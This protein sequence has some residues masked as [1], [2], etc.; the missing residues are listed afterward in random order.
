MVPDQV[1]GR[2]HIIKS[3]VDQL[4]DRQNSGPCWGVYSRFSQEKTVVVHSEGNRSVVRS[5]LY[6]LVPSQGKNFCQGREKSVRHKWDIQTVRNLYPYLDFFRG[7]KCK[8]K[9]LSGRKERDPYGFGVWRVRRKRDRGGLFL[10]R[11]CLR[12][13][14]ML[15]HYSGL[16]GVPVTLFWYRSK[17]RSDPTTRL[18]CD[19][20]FHTL[21]LDSVDKDRTGGKTGGV[22]SSTLYERCR[23]RY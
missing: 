19:W 13:Y 5:V 14:S 16:S 11:G 7:V 6:K 12:N 15:H 21:R 17:C 23:M 20:G 10:P 18:G 8:I 9:S 4:W 3:S 2:R 22:V 1:K